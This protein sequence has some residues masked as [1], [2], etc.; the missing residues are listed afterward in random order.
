MN[1]PRLIVLLLAILAVLPFTELVFSNIGTLWDE[2]SRVRI[3]G[4][5][6]ITDQE[7]IARLAILGILDA[8]ASAGGILLL[9]SALRPDRVNLIPVGQWLVLGG[10][11][12]YGLYQIVSALTVLAPVY[13]GVIGAGVV[14]ILLGML[15]YYLGSRLKAQL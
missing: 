8:V 14:Y 3:A 12:V 9:V 4:E 7:E 6:G 5:F 13:R 1:N 2:G 10:Y 11:G 15:G